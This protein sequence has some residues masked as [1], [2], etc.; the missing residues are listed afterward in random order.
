[1][2]LVQLLHQ[3]LPLRI[4]LLYGEDEEEGRVC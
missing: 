4:F 3:P 1:M 2:K